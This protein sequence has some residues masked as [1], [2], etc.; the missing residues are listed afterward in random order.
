MNADSIIEW[1]RSVLTGIG[2]D[3]PGIL[4]SWQGLVGLLIIL[5]AIYC[6]RILAGKVAS[7]SPV[8]TSGLLSVMAAVAW[9]SC[10]ALDASG[11]V[12]VALLVLG[13]WMVVARLGVFIAL[14]MV[15][16]PSKVSRLELAI[17]WILWA[18]VL[19][20]LLQWLDPV[21]NVLDAI[22]IPFGKSR[23]SLLDAVRLAVVLLLFI[24][25]ATYLGALVERRVLV[26]AQ[27]PIGLR[28][29]IA[30]VSR[31]VLVVLAVVLGLNALGVD[32]TAMTVIGGAV[33]VGIGFGLQRIASI[34]SVVSCCWGIVPSGLGT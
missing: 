32:L 28:V 17:G 3:P 24:G 19:L 14:R 8:A 7:A 16:S 34:S 20:L 13:G 2:A 11:L 5:A 6:G 25:G 21:V 22:A 9:A 26:V 23:V 10:I 27:L 4:W 33:G 30:K 15:V 18:I 12:F 29:G 1:M 31:V